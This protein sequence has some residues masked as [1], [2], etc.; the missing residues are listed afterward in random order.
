MFKKLFNFGKKKEE[1]QVEE[2][3]QSVEEVE[4]IETEEKVVEAVDF[5]L[6]SMEELDTQE[7]AKSEENENVTETEVEENTDEIVESENNE[8]IAS[9]DDVSSAIKDGSL[10]DLRLKSALKAFI[11]FTTSIASFIVS[12]G[13]IGRLNSCS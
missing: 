2:V 5:K 7:E 3:A 8:V 4:N 13:L 6:S 1:N 9:V 11:I 10:S 12:S